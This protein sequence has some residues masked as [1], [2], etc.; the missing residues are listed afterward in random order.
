MRAVI[1]GNTGCYLPLP[2]GEFMAE[3]L[4]CAPQFMGACWP[5]ARGL[6]SRI[7]S[8]SHAAHF[9]YLTGVCVGSSDLRFPRTFSCEAVVL[10]EQWAKSCLD[11]HRSTQSRQ[12]DRA[13]LARVFL[14]GHG[15]G[16]HPGPSARVY[17]IT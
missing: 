12:H 5:F 10:P 13:P 9:H 14:D 7:S 8:H 17:C 2:S 11:S 4:V 6:P 3:S 15:T 16:G 1:L